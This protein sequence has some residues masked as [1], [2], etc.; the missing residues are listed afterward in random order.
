MPAN[1]ATYREIE[2]EIVRRI[3]ALDGARHAQGDRGARWHESEIPLSVIGDPSS[4]GHLAFSAWI[5][6]APDTRLERSNEEDGYAYIG[7]R[8]MV[9][10]AFRLRPKRQTADARLATDAALEV[11]RTV[12]APWNPN[13]GDASVALVDGLQP[14]LSLDGE[15]ALVQQA[16]L[17]WF[18]LRLDPEPSVEVP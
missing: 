1:P 10:F 18:D 8:L 7:A 4:L 15:W 6:S 16:Y 12:L 2:E 14:S 11:T 13:I 9:A 3:S 5:Q 17:V